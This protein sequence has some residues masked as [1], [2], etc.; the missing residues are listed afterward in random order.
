M[1]GSL[2]RGGIIAGTGTMSDDGSVGPIGGIQQKIAGAA[3]AKSEIFL[4]P[5]DNC[6]EALA[7]SDH[8]GMRLARVSTF[9]DVRERFYVISPERKIRHPAVAAITESGRRL[10]EE[11]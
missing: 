5:A 2:T 4:V 3:D 11:E 1:P 9:D 7:A 6:P 10:L 8:D